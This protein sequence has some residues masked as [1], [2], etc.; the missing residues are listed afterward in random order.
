NLPAKI[1]QA[2]AR[3]LH[4]RAPA[5]PQHREFKLLRQSGIR[6][7]V[8]R[9]PA[10][11]RRVPFSGTEALRQGVRVPRLRNVAVKG[12]ALRVS[13]GKGFTIPR[14]NSR[15]S[16]SRL[17]WRSP[18]VRLRQAME[19]PPPALN[20]AVSSRTLPA[21]SPAVALRLPL[22]PRPTHSSQFHARGPMSPP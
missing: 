4:H 11:L 6:V 9:G 7:H 21:H 5:R 14:A 20:R 22:A 1:V 3:K 18:L 10:A 8:G 13:I 17:V 15:K 2:P 16:K 19:A 12:N